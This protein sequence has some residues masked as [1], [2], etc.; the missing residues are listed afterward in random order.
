[1]STIAELANQ[2]F[3]VDAIRSALDRRITALPDD[4]IE[5]KETLMAEIEP[6]PDDL[7]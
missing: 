5:G 7:G 6:V 1:M 4:D 3:K 2:Y